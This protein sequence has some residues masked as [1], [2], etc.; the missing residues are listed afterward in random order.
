MYNGFSDFIK[1]LEAE[2]E[3]LR[4]KAPVSTNLEIAEITDRF[5]KE[6]YGGKALLFENTGKNFPVITNAFGS[7]RRIS[8]ALGYLHIEQLAV[9][10]E[11]LILEFLSPRPKLINKLSIIPKISKLLK[12]IPKKKFSYTGRVPAQEVIIRQPDLDILPVLKTWPKDADKF[13][14][15]PV[16]ITKDPITG[17]RNVGMYRM[18]VIGHSTTAMHWHKH[19]VGAR[20][21]REYKKLGKKMPV[22]VVL[23]GDPVYTYVATAPLPDNVDEF[24]L[25]GYIRKRPVELVKAITQD[26]EVPADADIVIEGYIDPEEDLFLEGPFGDHTGFY[27]KPDFYPKFHITAITHRKNAVYPATLVGIP[28]MEDAYF[29]KITERIFIPLIRNS[30]VPEL[31]DMDLPVAGVSHNFAILKIKKSF[32]G[33]A[34]KIMNSLWGAG[35]MMF[36]K[37]MFIVS[38]EI[39]D[40]HNYK[41]LAQEAFKNFSPQYDVAFF[42]GPT[43]ILDHASG[44]TGLGSKIGLD[45]TVKFPN[46]SKSKEIKPRFDEETKRQILEKYP[47]IQQIN[48]S[49]LNDDIPVL[50]FSV[51]KTQPVNNLAE[52]LINSFDFTGIKILLWIDGDFDPDDVFTSL[53]LVGNNTDPLRDITILF[54]YTFQNFVLSVDGTAK[55]KEIDNFTEYWPEMTVMDKNTIEKVNSRWQ[56]YGFDKFIPSPSLKFLK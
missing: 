5:S 40:I 42:K 21:F 27:S 17:I 24:I 29:A 55:N 25:A 11:Q 39:L 14:T 34:N 46:E 47:E 44:K 20:H 35:Q 38:E 51:N 22:A 43:D 53:W 2:G 28:P 52:D 18:Q 56:E 30:F 19:K 8:L 15:L 9:E 7:E 50:L 33:Q 4:I 41:R 10:L 13:I 31:I 23:G 16:V 36:N 54:S 1:R 49:L 48:H 45:F 32:E 12:L 6:K 3:L 26:I 37:F